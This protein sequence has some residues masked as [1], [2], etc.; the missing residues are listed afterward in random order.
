MILQQRWKNLMT[1]FS[2]HR[3]LIYNVIKNCG[4]LNATEYVY[5]IFCVTC[6]YSSNISH[7]SYGK[8][9]YGETFISIRWT[10]RESLLRITPKDS[11]QRHRVPN[12]PPA[13]RQ[14]NPPSP[15]KLPQLFVIRDRGKCSA[16]RK[17][18][19]RSAR[20]RPW[21]SRI[22]RVSTA[23]IRYISRPANESSR[24]RTPQRAWLR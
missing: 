16:T 7:L 21:D 4:T 9:K 15:E 1:F 24:E 3:Y 17:R 5:Y 10:W 2:V 20:K 13:I 18:K 12:H 11:N 14:N 23:A 8:K 22:E 19:K 6:I